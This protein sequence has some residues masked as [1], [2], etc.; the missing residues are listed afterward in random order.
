MTPFDLRKLV[1]E[2]PSGEIAILQSGRLGDLWF[3]TPLAHALHQLGATV[4]VIHRADFGNPFTH[5]PYAISSPAPAPVPTRTDRLGY[6]AEEAAWQWRQWRRLR[7]EATPVIWNQIFPFRW[8]PALASGHS[9]PEYWYRRLPGI[10]FRRAPSTLDLATEPLVL[11]FRRSFS[12]RGAIPDRFDAWMRDTVR[13]IAAA[14]GFR[15]LVVATNSEPDDEDHATWR[16]S[17]EEFQRLVA[18]C[19]IVAGITTSGHVLG[20]LLGKHVVAMYPPGVRSIDRIGAETIA[21]EFPAPPPGP[22][23]LHRLLGTEP[24]GHTPR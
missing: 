4:R 12:F 19:S 18:K 1:A 5:F 16:G 17:L 9:Y 22:H 23:I 15:V 10:D 20:Q 7:A 11:F 24:S 21:L 14:T 3:V 2:S 8:L 6:A 13:Q